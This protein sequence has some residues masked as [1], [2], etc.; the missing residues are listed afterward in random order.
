MWRRDSERGY[1][2]EGTKREVQRGRGKERVYVTEGSECRR[3]R[4]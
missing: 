1:V 3:R 2:E 4:D